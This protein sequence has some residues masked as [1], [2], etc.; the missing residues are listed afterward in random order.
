MPSAAS[1]GALLVFDGDCGFCTTAV[2]WLQRALPAMPEAMPY[3]W[4][5]LDEH[6]LT[7]AD[8]A[9]RV[10]LLTPTRRYGGHLAVSAL[11]RHQDAP[12]LRAVGWLMTVPPW[13]WIA[14][15]GYT[16]VAK[17]RYRLPGGT[18]ACRVGGAAR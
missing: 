16:L 5:P 4:T 6:G 10:W 2:G 1:S 11:L 7:S 9:A 18:P 3:Q 17:Y 8:A 13:S 12:A 15:L 14:A